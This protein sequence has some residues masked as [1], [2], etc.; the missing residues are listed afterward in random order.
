MNEILKKTGRLILSY[1][2]LDFTDALHY[3]G[4]RISE[5]P[6]VIKGVRL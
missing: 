6:R 5:I 2:S 3:T 4:S 1:L